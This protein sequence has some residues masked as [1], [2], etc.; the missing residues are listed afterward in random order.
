MSSHPLLYCPD[1]D[2]LT[3]RDVRVLLEQYKELVLLHEAV[4]RVR[5]HAAYTCLLQWKAFL[6]SLNHTAAFKPCRLA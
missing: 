5:L 3:L 2:A 4:A 1:A 6:S